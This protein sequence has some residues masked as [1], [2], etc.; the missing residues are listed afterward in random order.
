MRKNFE[1]QLELGATAIES[2]RLNPRSRDDIP[3]LL[4]GLQFIYSQPSVRDQ[5][6]SVL[7]AGIG[8]DIDF[9]NGRP[10]M[11]LWVLLVLGALRLGANCDYDRLHELANEHQTLRAMLGHGKWSEQA[12]NLQTLKDNVRLLTEE[13]LEEINTLVV[14]AGHTFIKKKENDTALHARC[15]SFVVE[16][17]VEFPTDIGLLH[18]AVR[19]ILKLTSALCSEFGIKG[20]R[21]SN[22]NLKKLKRYWRAAQQSNRSRKS[23]AAQKKISAYTAYLTV[24]GEYIERSLLSVWDIEL[25]GKSLAVEQW[26]RLHDKLADIRE[27]QTHAMRQIEQIERRVLHEETIPSNEKVYSLFEPH[28]EWISKGKAGVPVELGVKVCI[29]EDQN[30]FILHHRVMEKEQD[31]HVAV[32]MIDACKKKFPTLSSCSFD[33]GFHSPDNQIQLAERL[34]EVILPKKGKLNSVDKA[35]T[36]ED[37]YRAKKK[38]HS[39]VES[40]I[41]GLEQTGLDRCP[42]QGIEGFRRYVALSVL[43][44][45]LQR[46]G[47][48]VQ[49]HEHNRQVSTQ[50]MTE[51]IPIAA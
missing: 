23:D 25:A 18:D 15:D 6:F 19:K 10:G 14:H 46:I 44:R 50:V 16:T 36:Q 38:Q 22:N 24:A 11:E 21:Q 31:A 7:T 39:A 37:S 51:R 35:L 4:Y 29:I 40:A 42:D 1:P 49:A 43:A 27:Y 32:A 26:T 5:I 12:Y 48:L 3:A 41:N 17:D 34:D 9:G 45:N 20:W 33:R 13:M 47:G 2:I 28:T 8:Q 30:Q